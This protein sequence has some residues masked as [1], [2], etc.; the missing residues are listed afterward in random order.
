MNKCPECGK[1][2]VSELTGFCWICSKWVM[3]H[4]RIK[5]EV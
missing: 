1:Y 4:D 2:A 3:Q 5:R